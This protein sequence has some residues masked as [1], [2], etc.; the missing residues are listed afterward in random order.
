MNEINMSIDGIGYVFTFIL[1]NGSEYEYRTLDRYKADKIRSIAKY[2]PFK[3]LNYAK[4]SCEMTYPVKKDS[5]Q[6]E[7][8]F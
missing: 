7:F 6:M 5:L 4:K 1:D 3:A 2:A 8:S